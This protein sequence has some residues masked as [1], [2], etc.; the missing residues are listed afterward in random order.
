MWTLSGFADEIS[1]DLVEQCSVLAGLDMHHLEFRGAWET[2]IS[3]FD[4]KQLA[5]AAAILADHAIAVSSI[6]S[7]IGKVSVADDFD[8]HLERFE[9][10]LHA[11]DI[12]GARYLRLFSF[13]PAPGQPVAEAREEVL[14]RLS[15]LV[16]RAAGRDVVLLHEN[17]KDIYGDIPSRCVDLLS[18]VDSPILR[19]AWDAANFVQCGVDPFTEGYALLRQWIDYV[20]V[21]DARAADGVVT[22][23]GQGDGDLRLT[24]AALR[25]DGF[26]GFFSLEPHLAEVGRFG[27]FSGPELFGVAHAA[28]TDLLTELGIDHV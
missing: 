28:F 6:G 7:P 4:E 26:D 24:L 20:H 18:S 12:L 9:R 3:D 14:R 22:P 1:D 25:D 23:A 11:A 15:K 17:E 13:Y 8:A 19:A 16:D 21:K 5:E 27:G 2:N 10:C